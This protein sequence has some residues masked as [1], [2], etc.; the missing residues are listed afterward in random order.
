MAKSKVK[1]SKQTERK[2]NPELVKTILAAKKHEGWRG[3]AEILS[4]PRRI[5]INLN[6]G[7]LDKNSKT[8]ET[9]VV[10]GKVLSQ[11]EITKKVNIIALGLSEKAKDKLLKSGCKVSNILNEIKK[12]PEGKG[13]RVLK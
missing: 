11:G 3:V 7:D 2:T 12:N 8:G 13:V 6:L 10:P 5:R 9:I 4:S 1:I